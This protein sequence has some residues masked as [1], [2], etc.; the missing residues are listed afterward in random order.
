[1]T[2]S[3]QELACIHAD[4]LLIQQRLELA[5]GLKEVLA[6]T[7]ARQE[8]MF[9]NTIKRDKQS[10]IYGTRTMK[11]RRIDDVALQEAGRPPSSAAVRHRQAAPKV[12]LHT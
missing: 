9:L 4:A 11:D 6:K 8:Q 7:A 2:P 1:M 3:E 5:A 12:G 10:A